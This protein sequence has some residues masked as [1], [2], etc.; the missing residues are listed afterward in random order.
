MTETRPAARWRR[1]VAFAF[2]VMPTVFEAQ[3]EAARTAPILERLEAHVERH[4]EVAE[5]LLATR[6]QAAGPGASTTLR[7]TPD[8]ADAG[9]G[10]APAATPPEP[11][12]ASD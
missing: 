7:G 11:G 8:S 3:Y 12:A 4:T 9:A 1:P 5:T 2:V 10:S 6:D